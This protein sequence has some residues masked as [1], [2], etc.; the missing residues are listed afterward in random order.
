MQN[1]ICIKRRVGDIPDCAL[2]ESNF[3]KLFRVS[4]LPWKRASSSAT[5]FFFFFR[6]QAI[7]KSVTR[8]RSISASYKAVTCEREIWR[9]PNIKKNANIYT[10]WIVMRNRDI[11][12]FFL[13]FIY[14]DFIY[15]AISYRIF[16]DN[17]ADADFIRMFDRFMQLHLY[18]ITICSIYISRYPIYD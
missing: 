9:I 12:D 2:R 13:D 18:L 10:R 16:H 4:Q 5:N 8:T 14:C 3:R 11:S 1:Y 17:H 7:P 15:T 6:A